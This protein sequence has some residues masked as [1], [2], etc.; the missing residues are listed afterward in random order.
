MLRIFLALAVVLAIAAPLIAQNNNPCPGDK[1]YQFNIIGTKTKNANLNDNNGHRIFVPL[2]GR[3]SIY[4]TGDTSTD[5]GLQCGN[6]FD[7]LDPNGT[8][9]RATLLVPC[10]ELTTGNLDPDVCF[11]V[12][13]T[14][15]GTPGGN[16][17]VDV[18]CDFDATC[19][20]CDIDEGSCGTGTIDFS[21]AGHSGK[22]LTK[23]VT[24][25]FRASGCID[26]DANG[27]DAGDINFN[28]EWI[29]NIAALESYY[30][31][32][33]NQGNRIVNIRFCDVED[34]PGSDCGPNNIQS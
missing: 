33:D 32:Y 18:V 27:C 6:N 16:T 23:D 22:P 15:L 21:L 7:V 24:G 31:D 10:D 5:T 28:N 12:Y 4:M 30:W 11:D 9:G 2:T 1:E 13:A 25:F 26:L 29:F 34:V 19:I 8:D 20:A 17:D 14:P 3:T